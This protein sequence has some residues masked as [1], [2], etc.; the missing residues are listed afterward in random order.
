MSYP[1]K[2]TIQRLVVEVEVYTEQS[3]NLREEAWLRIVSDWLYSTF[4]P[5]LEEMLDKM[6]L[7]NER[8][9]L[10]QLTLD[11][12]E[13]N[14]T[15]WKELSGFSEGHIRQT[16]EIALKS[17]QE[18]PAY[19]RPSEGQNTME[20]FLFFLKTGRLPWWYTPRPIS[21]WESQIMDA[22]AES[23]PKSGLLF[24]D[25]AVS[26]RL[27]GHFSQS[28]FQ[29]LIQKY[30][31]QY[32][33]RSAEIQERIKRL[34][35]ALH[36]S[37]S[38]RQEMEAA[39]RTTLLQAFGQ[40]LPVE[41]LP[42]Y[43]LNHLPEKAFSV[44]RKATLALAAG[45][46]K[47]EEDKQWIELIAAGKEQI[48]NKSWVVG[49]EIRGAEE[50]LSE[51][52]TT[53]EIYITNAGLVL[54]HPFITYFFEE[55]NISKNGKI[56]KPQ[57][58]VMLLQWLASGQSDPAEYDLPLNKLL[59]GL[60]PEAPVV[61]KWKLTKRE[62][63]EARQ[64][65]EA[66]IRHWHVLRN[67]STA[68]LQGNFLCREGKLTRKSEGDW[69]LQIERKSMDILLADL[70]WGISMIQLPWMPHWLW[71]EWA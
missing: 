67:T 4:L 52:Q 29:K 54:L 51:T 3:D 15:E 50:R 12:G 5:L 59:C 53:D 17:V 37:Q 13:I 42:M 25:T 2:H 24:K 63:N 30:F 19:K 44:L 16:I 57:R 36:L 68:G 10:A 39:V 64:L 21:E 1:Q 43:V 27:A 28:L 61:G 9:C 60:S 11:L 55:L 46:G 20:A 65:L 8:I 18:V 32:Y 58:A 33:E 7:S 70:P 23:P 48:M 62:K 71:V 49:Q 66:V 31:G 45:A 41:Q 26:L 56:L 6:A 40:N 14:Q 35:T 34:V 38:R 22:L 47:R 69:L